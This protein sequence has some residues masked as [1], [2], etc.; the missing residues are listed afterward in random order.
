[1][2]VLM[3]LSDCVEGLYLTLVELRCVLIHYGPLCVTACGTRMVQEL[4]VVNWDTVNTVRSD[5][6][7][8]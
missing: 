3:A 6:Y 5:D 8:I 2:P 7:G 4:C 1:M